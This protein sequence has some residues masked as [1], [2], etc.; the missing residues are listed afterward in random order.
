MMSLSTVLAL[1][2]YLLIASFLWW[3]VTYVISHLPFPEPVKTYGPVIA[4]IVFAVVIVY[5]L[6]QL[7]GGHLVHVSM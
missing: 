1:V 4:T 7:L 6:L 5:A 2:V 3:L